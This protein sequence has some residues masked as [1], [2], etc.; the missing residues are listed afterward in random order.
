MASSVSY[1]SSPVLPGFS[2]TA[3]GISSVALMIPPSSSVISRLARSISLAA[4]A[5]PTA[6]AV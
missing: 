2:R 1:R 4:S 3:E 6:W 5:S